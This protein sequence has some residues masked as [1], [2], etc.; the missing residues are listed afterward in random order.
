M[1]A[2]MRRAILILAAAGTAVLAANPAP[3][4]QLPD[5]NVDRGHALAQTWSRQQ[6]DDGVVYI[7][8]LRH[9]AS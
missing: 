7:I 3:A 8:G 5:G 6:I 1:E 9:T 4:Q 2:A